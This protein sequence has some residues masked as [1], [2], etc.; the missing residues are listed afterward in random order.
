MRSIGTK[1][2][3]AVGLFA[4]GFSGLLVWRTW[5]STKRHVRALT[6]R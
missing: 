4:L 1:F 5:S 2:V 6:A 3:L